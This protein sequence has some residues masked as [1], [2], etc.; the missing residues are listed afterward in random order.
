M[1]GVVVTWIE[2]GDAAFLNMWV[3]VDISLGNWVDLRLQRVHFLVLFFVWLLRNL[4]DEE[5]EVFGAFGLKARIPISFHGFNNRQ[6]GLMNN[7]TSTA[8]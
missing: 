2:V 8:L 7:K 3:E 5:Y 4:R 6:R 1:H